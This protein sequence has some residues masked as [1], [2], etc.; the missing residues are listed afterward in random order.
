MQILS[1]LHSNYMG[2]E[3]MM[4]L[5]HESVYWV[6]INTDIK[7]IKHCSTCLE[8]W[9]MQ[10]QEKTVHNKVLTKLWEVVDTDIF[11]ASN[12]TLLC[13]VDYY[14]KFPL[15]KKVESIS[16]EDLI[17]ATK[18]VLAEFGLPRRFCDRL[19]TQICFRMV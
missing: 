4:L 12:E 17:W 13:I 3:K 8:C 16:A 1:Q 10:V 14:S 5:V 7:T 19:W 9:N 11:K 2:I 15:V 6:N 18:V